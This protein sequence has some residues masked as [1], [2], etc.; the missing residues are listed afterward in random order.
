MEWGGDYYRLR[1]YLSF[2]VPNATKQE[3]V[4][5]WELPSSCGWLYSG[6]NTKSTVKTAGI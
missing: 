2:L 4:Q 1:D 3:G 6:E 5:F